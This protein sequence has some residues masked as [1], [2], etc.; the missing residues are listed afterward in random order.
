MSKYE[1]I[2]FWIVFYI[3]LSALVHSSASF[4][5]PVVLQDVLMIDPI[6]SCCLISWK[7]DPWQLYF[8][9]IFR[10][11]IPEH[12]GVTVSLH[13]GIFFPAPKLLNSFGPRPLHHF[14]VSQKNIN[15]FQANVLY[16][17]KIWENLWFLMFSE[18]IAHWPEMS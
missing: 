2:I 4:H 8:S 7:H 12:A 17:L 16:I 11:S 6:S 14:V 9:E 3:V 5:Y 1:I 10:I 13:Q 18:D 15:L